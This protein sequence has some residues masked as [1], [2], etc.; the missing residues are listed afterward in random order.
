G[1][2]LAEQHP[3]LS[4]P[5][6]HESACRS[7]E[8][9]DA[10]DPADDLRGVLDVGDRGPDHR[11]GSVDGYPCFNDHGVPPAGWSERGAMDGRCS[12]D[13]A[14]LAYRPEPKGLRTGRPMC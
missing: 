3:G 14:W 1:R 6:S 12:V 7:F 10:L 13:A 8:N 2:R 4:P 11:P 9:L 5:Q